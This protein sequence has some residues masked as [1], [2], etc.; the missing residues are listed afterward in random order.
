MKIRILPILLLVG[1]G[2]FGLTQS[3]PTQ[4][5]TLKPNN[6][7]VI[8]ANPANFTPALATSTPA[9]AT[10]ASAEAKTPRLDPTPTQA[11]TASATTLNTAEKIEKGV[12]LVGP[13][14]QQFLEEE[15]AVGETPQDR[16]AAEV[17]RVE[18][19]SQR[20]VAEQSSVDSAYDRFDL[21]RLRL[22][23]LL[24]NSDLHTAS[25]DGSSGADP[26]K[27]SVQLNLG[28]SGVIPDASTK[29]LASTQS[30]PKLWPVKGPVTSTFGPRQTLTIP[31]T[32]DNAAGKGGA[33][34]TTP[35][36]GQMVSV[37]A[38]TPIPTA[39]V[40]R[41]TTTPVTP[42]PTT[43]TAPAPTNPATTAP[44]APPS[45]PATATPAP[46]STIGPTPTVGPPLT[47]T[48]PL[49]ATP[50]ISATATVSP[51]VTPTATPFPTGPVP[52]I[53]GTLPTVGTGEE[54]HTGFDIAVPEGTEVHVTADGVVVYAGNGGGYG[55]VVYIQ[56]ADGFMTVYGH[57]S[58]LLVEVGQTVKAGQTIALSGSTGYS[59]GPHVHYEVRYNGK[60]ADPAYFL[61]L[62]S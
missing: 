14:F 4:A 11:A 35:A 54:Y 48:P 59:T 7:T 18:K 24:S 6:P 57:N 36:T 50:T 10:S 61:G 28:S 1:I 21:S 45:Q 56:H 20:V 32:T 55:R 19:A 26:I 30:A 31:A 27:V 16:E 46:Q 13:A 3:D 52:T 8:A 47:P 17:D 39:S 44:I 51:T 25:L 2:V 37:P 12:V 5:T 60:I 53:N 23:N 38:I 29:T 49:T 41:A 34:P 40:A 62:K 9:P 15:G 22:A 33:G 43:T 42:T 58:K